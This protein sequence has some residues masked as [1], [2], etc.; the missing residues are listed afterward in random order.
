MT[1]RRFRDLE[2]TGKMLEA[3]IDG[4][5]GAINPIYIQTMSL[6]VGSESL[7]FRF[8]NSKTSPSE[9]IPNFA[10]NQSTTVFTAPSTILQHMTLGISKRYHQHI[11]ASE[12]QILDPMSSYTSP[13]LDVPD[14]HGKMPKNQNGTT[15][16]F[17]F[18]QNSV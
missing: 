15:G 13:S 5:S 11:Q 16:S 3:A 8:V 1:K 14:A 4:F 2:E 7:Q 12:P 9:I 6:Q 17:I 10:Y 18:E